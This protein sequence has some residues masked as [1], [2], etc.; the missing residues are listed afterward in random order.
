MIR[1]LAQAGGVQ[2][3]AA[4]ALGI[5]R[6]TLQGMMKKHGLDKAVAG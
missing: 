6:T 2:T 1:A 4:E 3:R 5:P